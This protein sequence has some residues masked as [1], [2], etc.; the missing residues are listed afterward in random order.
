MND[1]EQSAYRQKLEA[2]LDQWQAEIDKLQAKAA[3]ASADARLEHD[4][5]IQN[6]RRQQQEARDK[7]N[8]LEDAGSEASE[9]LK[10][11]LEQAWDELGEAVDKAKKRFA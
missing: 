10:K 7:L 2:R 9:D 5:Q 8:K 6:L 3:E 4:E 1:Q 11:G